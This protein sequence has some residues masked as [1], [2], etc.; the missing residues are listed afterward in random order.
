MKEAT[1]QMSVID[2]LSPQRKRQ[3]TEQSHKK[4]AAP[5]SSREEE[6]AA[7]AK[8]KPGEEEPVVVIED[9]KEVVCV[10]DGSRDSKGRNLGNAC[11]SD[12]AKQSS[13]TA[14]SSTSIRLSYPSQS[15]RTAT[16]TRL[17]R[18]CMYKRKQ[19]QPSTWNKRRAAQAPPDPTVSSSE[20]NRLE[21]LLLFLSHHFNNQ[22]LGFDLS[23]LAARYKDYLL[24]KQSKSGANLPWEQKYRPRDLAK[25]KTENSSLCEHMRKWLLG[26]S[27]R[28]IDDSSSDS[29]WFEGE[30]GSREQKRGLLLFGPSGS[31]KTATI[32]S[33]ASTLG[34]GVVEMNSSESR[35][36]VT[37]RKKIME[38]TQSASSKD[39]IAKKIIVVEEI[40]NC[41]DEDHGFLSALT[42]VLRT[43]KRP[44]VLTSNTINI[45]QNIINLVESLEFKEPRVGEIFC[46][47]ALICVSEKI[48]M[49]WAKLLEYVHGHGCDYRS[50]VNDLQLGV[51]G[52]NFSARATLMKYDVKQ[53][54]SAL[55]LH[56]SL[57]SD[58]VKSSE[59]VVDLSHYIDLLSHLDNMNGRALPSGATSHSENVLAVAVEQEPFK[60]IDL[61][62]TGSIIPTKS[63]D[64]DGPGSRAK[65]ADWKLKSLEAVVEKL[66]A[67]LQ[68]CDRYSRRDKL[69][70]LSSVANLE[71]LRFQYGGKRK[72]KFYHYL[73][74]SPFFYD[75]K[76]IGQI[77]NLL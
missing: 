75:E 19:Q 66:G 2:M 76:L 17:Y 26:W 48:E 50:C 25:H 15:L 27:L 22:H 51:C 33:L 9:G 13:G 73:A 70:C 6:A 40:D 31:G 21:T 44:I 39:S 32:A 4:M 72:R 49:D 24:R 41:C 45:P 67:G 64:Y 23:H 34:Q 10:S 8:A 47:C 77:N 43:T 3:T 16:R 38:A 52:K 37:L 28:K 46:H 74:T 30:A 62:L 57:C 11:T 35:T 12:S 71:N 29:D 36:G 63:D 55:H 18:P 1:R 69:A 59:S 68:V 61:D 56:D 53:S 58:K 60:K 42:E 14:D 65:R 5:V 7:G 54:P 20:M